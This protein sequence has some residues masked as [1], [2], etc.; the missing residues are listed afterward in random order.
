M[1]VRDDAGAQ[2]DTGTIAIPWNSTIG[3][4]YTNFLLSQDV[5]KHTSGGSGDSAKIDQ[6]LAAV[7]RTW[8]GA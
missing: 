5:I 3:L 7:Y 6:I 1:E 4:A 8:L 2:I